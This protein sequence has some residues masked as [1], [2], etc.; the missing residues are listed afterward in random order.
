MTQHISR[1]AREGCDLHLDIVVRAKE[2]EYLK[3]RTRLTEWCAECQ[4]FYS[5]ETIEN[6]KILHNAIRNRQDDSNF[7]YLRAQIANQVRASFYYL[8]PFDKTRFRNFC[9]TRIS[10]G[11]AGA[12]Y[13]TTLQKQRN[14]DAEYHLAYCKSRVLSA[15]GGIVKTNVEVTSSVDNLYISTNLNV[16]NLIL[17]GYSVNNIASSLE[18]RASSVLRVIKYLDKELIERSQVNGLYFSS[19]RTVGQIFSTILGIQ[20]EHNKTFEWLLSPKG[21]RLRVDFYFS[22][23]SLAIEFDGEQHY[24]FPNSWHTSYEEFLYVRACD[25]IKNFELPLHGI[26]LLRIRENEKLNREH[27]ED[28]LRDVMENYETIY[29]T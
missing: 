19:E 21:K 10:G 12:I 2:E 18:C 6:H 17:A 23:F 22:A 25:E 7:R 11:R 27:L 14:L 1:C 28:R 8:K 20:P 16:K 3:Q 15:K 9:K 13:T 24:S 26:K 29:Y 4:T 5:K